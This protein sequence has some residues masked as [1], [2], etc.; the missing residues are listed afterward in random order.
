MLFDCRKI[1]VK[2]FESTAFFDDILRAD[3]NMTRA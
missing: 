2:N 1:N 3:L